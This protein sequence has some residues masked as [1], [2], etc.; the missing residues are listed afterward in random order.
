ELGLVISGT[1][2]VFNLTKDQNNVQNQLIL[3]VMGVDVSLEEIK[4][5]TPRFTLCPN[6]YYFAIDPNGYVLLH[7]NLQPKHIGVGIPKVKQR[8]PYV[9]NPK[10]Q[11][12]VTLDFLDAELEN[13]IK[14]EIRKKMI[15]SESGDRTFQTLVKS[16]DERYID[17]GNRTYT[18]TKVNG[19][20]YSLALVLPSYSFYYIKAKINETLTQAK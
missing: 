15:D 7:P 4:K 17:R 19:T 20:D 16:Q 1:L 18:W 3:G 11:E 6:G 5:L 13:D 10:S 14:V 9:Q 2:P 12:P 8:R